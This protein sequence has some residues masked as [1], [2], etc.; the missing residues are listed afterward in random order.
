MKVTVHNWISVTSSGE[1]LDSTT[2][3]IRLVDS[4]QA[5]ILYCQM[6]LYETCKHT[7]HL[8][9]GAHGDSGA[10][11]HLG[12]KSESE[13]APLQLPG[14]FSIGVSIGFYSNQLLLD[15]KPNVHRLTCSESFGICVADTVC[16][17]HL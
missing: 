6:F 4:F 12:S 16:W 15:S 13:L 17:V 2:L 14:H 3:T 8:T 5:N 1:L 11:E 9:P 10:Q 7:L